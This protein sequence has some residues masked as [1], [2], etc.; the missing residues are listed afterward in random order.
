MS[1][2]PV[3]VEKE[4]GG[5][6]SWDLYS[7]LLKDRIIFVTGEIEDNMASVIVAQLLYLDSENDNADIYLYVN[8]PGGSVTAGMAIIDTINVIK[9]PVSTIG[10][11]MCASMGA[12]ILSQGEK[13]KRYVLP[14]A[15]VMIH[16]PL[17]GT[18][19]QATDISIYA[20]N[21]LKTKEKLAKMIADSC[22]RPIDSVRQDM[23]RDNYMEAEEALNY[24]IVDHIMKNKK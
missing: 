12:M 21:I 4:K 5:E 10:V 23:E 1:L 19:G 3:V 17:G 16:Q 13:G 9:S 7:R 14:N 2:I 22:G 20:N 18:K 24:G 8:S 11:G 15:E 6:R